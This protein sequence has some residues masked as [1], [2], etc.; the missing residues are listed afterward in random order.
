MLR[1]THRQ[2]A[3]I[4][5]QLRSMSASSVG[6]E[7]TESRITRRSRQRAPHLNLSAHPVPTI[8]PTTDTP[9]DQ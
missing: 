5:S 6:A 4:A 7:I 3:Q 1:A 8:Q 2:A 9:I